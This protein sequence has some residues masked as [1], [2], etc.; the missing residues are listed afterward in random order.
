MAVF[1]TESVL[2]GL[3]KHR[4]KEEERAEDVGRDEEGEVPG[5]REAL[6][7]SVG[8]CHSRLSVT[9]CR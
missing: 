2:E 5:M 3:K 7:V 4:E 9:V 1:S 8:L 6:T